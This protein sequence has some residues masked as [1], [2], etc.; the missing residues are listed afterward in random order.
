MGG[1]PPVSRSPG[2]QSRSPRPFSALPRGDAKPGP[3]LQAAE[4]GGSVCLV[5]K[6]PKAPVP[7]TCSSVLGSPGKARPRLAQA[8]ARPAE[9]PRSWGG[10]SGR[11]DLGDRLPL[12]TFCA[13]PR[14]AVPVALRCGEGSGLK[15]AVEPREGPYAHMD[16]RSGRPASESP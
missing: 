9:S 7:G 8:G 11:A 1:R 6:Y 16:G 13:C 3:S 12:P 15:L 5:L 14:R 4:R 2:R 10:R